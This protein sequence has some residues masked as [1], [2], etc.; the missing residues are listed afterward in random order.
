MTACELTNKQK[1]NR[2]NDKYQ[3]YSFDQSHNQQNKNGKS[4][5]D[6]VKKQNAKSQI[7]EFV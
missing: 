3:K 2:E 1:K 7:Q 6:L 4:Q 5:Q